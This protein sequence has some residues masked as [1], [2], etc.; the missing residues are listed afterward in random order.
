MREEGGSC[1]GKRGKGR[2]V[3]VRACLFVLNSCSIICIKKVSDAEIEGD[4]DDDDN[5][6]D[7]DDDDDDGKT[8][9]T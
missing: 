3:E 9:M 8:G 1:G 6:D 2:A 5:D 4:D 7:D